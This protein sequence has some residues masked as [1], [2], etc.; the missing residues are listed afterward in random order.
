M[1]VGPSDITVNKQLG[2]E[3]SSRTSD[4]LSD[5][6]FGMNLDVLAEIT[7]RENHYWKSDQSQDSLQNDQSTGYRSFSICKGCHPSIL[8]QFNIDAA[9]C[10]DIYDVKMV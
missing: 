4:R 9:I 1:V 7:V 2:P 10:S 5:V 3:N 8:V 6:K